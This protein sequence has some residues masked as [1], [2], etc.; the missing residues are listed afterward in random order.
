[1]R[2]SSTLQCA[3]ESKGGFNHILEADAHHITQVLS[4]AVIYL[5]SKRGD[6]NSRSQ[7]S[8]GKQRSIGL[9]SV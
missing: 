2:C 7:Q 5:P 9:A 8:N 3:L 4:T 1:M 6:G